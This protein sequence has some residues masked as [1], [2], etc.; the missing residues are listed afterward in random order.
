MAHKHAEAVPQKAKVRARVFCGVGGE[1]RGAEFVC[2]VL[3]TAVRRQQGGEAGRDRRVLLECG[4][5]CC[6]SSVEGVFERG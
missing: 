3:G 1:Y 4:V 5:R 2:V 6:V